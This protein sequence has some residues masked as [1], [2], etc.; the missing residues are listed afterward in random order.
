MKS[1]SRWFQS[2]QA[3]LILWAILPVTLVI[4]A[5]AF[6]G[7]YAHQ[8]DMQS[9]VSERNAL[10]VELIAVQIEDG[11]IHGIIE[12]DGTTL[13]QW[14][15]PISS[16]ISGSLFVINEV[17]EVLLHTG[18][19]ALSAS[20]K[21][22][23]DQQ[24][25]EQQQG[26]ALVTD[27]DDNFLVSYARVQGTQWIVVLQESVQG[28]IGPILRFSNLGPVVA[29]IAIIFSIL[30][31]SFGWRTI[32][33]PL[34][35]LSYASEQVSWGNHSALDFSIQ[36]VAEIQG[37][38]QALQNMLTRIEGYEI[39]IRD[40]VDAMTESQESERTRLARELHDGPVQ[41]LI[42]L[43]QRA[44]M[45]ERYINRDQYDNALL[46]LE[47][48]RAREITIVEELRR[49]IGD[50]R[51]IYLDDLGLVPALEMLV[52]RIEKQQDAVVS[53]EHTKDSERLCA[54]TE[55]TV[56]RIAQEALNNALQHA[57][58]NSIA[59]AL[60][61]DEQGIKL[62]VTDDGIGFILEPNMYSYTQKGHFGLVGIQERV[63]QLKGTFNIKSSSGMGTSL[64]VIIPYDECAESV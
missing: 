55:L 58:A 39:S 4:I 54:N 59:I 38:H 27:N 41:T 36:G 5:L 49:I 34:Q 17:G 33:R 13:S 10:V 40:Y 19:L 46:A 11:L 42:T 32:V 18:D 1:I 45:T 47:E 25:G 61:P 63:R 52:R 44:E 51:P 57:K 2:L 16:Q 29:L 56:Y 62:S 24:L 64:T 26:A 9:F 31:L 7:V 28:L 12:P 50:L 8:S 3:Q 43:G 15:P 21:I 14:I 22:L 48:L 20:T 6:T 60:S 30:I 37:L 35:R 53:F 23:L